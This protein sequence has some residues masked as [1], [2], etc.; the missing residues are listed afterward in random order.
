[1]KI[2]IIPLLF[3]FFSNIGNTQSLTELLAD[4]QQQVKEVQTEKYTYVQTLEYD[5]EKPYQITYNLVAVSN[6]KGD[7]KTFTYH[8]N[9]GDIAANQVRWNSKNGMKI[10]M[11]TIRQQPLIQYFEEGEQQNYESEINIYCENI[12]NARIVE[13]LLKS[14]IPIAKKTWE[15][16]VELPQELKPLLNWLQVEVGQVNV[17]D[18][19]IEQSLSLSPDYPDRIALEVT[20]TDAKGKVENYVQ[21]WSFGDIHNPSLKM[22]I[23][24][25]L[26]FV[27]AKTQ[28]TLK[29]IEQIDEEGNKSFESSFRLYTE[30]PDKAAALLLALDKILSLARKAQ[31]ARMQE[32][33]TP[34]DALTNLVD[35][36]QP[37]ELSESRYTQ[38]LS[39]DCLST[40][41]IEM[42]EKNKDKSEQYQFHFED[43]NPS[44]IKVKI[45][46]SLLEVEVG[47]KQKKK[48]IQVV[49]NES[50]AYQN[51]LSLKLPDVETARKTVHLLKM[52]IEECPQEIPVQSFD[53]LN[54]AI[55][56]IS[57]L[58]P[59]ITQSLEMASDNNCHVTFQKSEAKKKETLEETYD[60]NWGDVNE[61]VIE[62]D[63]QKNQP[64]LILTANRNQEIFSYS[65]SKGKMDYEKDFSILIKDIQTGKIAVATAK[66][67]VKKCKE[68]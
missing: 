14:A 39:P 40:Y 68:K 26:V 21:R 17:G 53:W 27:E 66:D 50:I 29:Y 35:L 34:A 8:F 9:L 44:T 11:K 18:K 13:K 45:R 16:S 23:K 12:D 3:L 20:E 30:S 60:F 58:N 6:K 65:S 48:F 2:S 1:M 64:V 28:R 47:T 55:M 61:K 7:S 4:I 24:G 15:E 49:D 22:N 42:Q 46:K 54:Q 43:F 36:I 57:D 56:S 41:T 59:S 51:K 38:Q 52:V 5:E 31:Q 33:S 19:S 62:L 37:F 67:L 63:L 32:V 25:K 10:M